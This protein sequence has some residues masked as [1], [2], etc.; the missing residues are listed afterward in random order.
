MSADGK[1]V[2][3]HIPES[4]RRQLRSEVGFGCPWDRCGVPYLEYH[5]FDPPF[6]EEAHHRPEGMIALC[7]MHHARA[8][9]LTVEQ[10]RK[11]K[12]NR[13]HGVEGRFD[14][15]R[16]EIVAIVGG[17]Y[18]HE[19]PNV[20]VFNGVPVIYFSR[21]AEG[22]LLLSV[23]M[24]TKSDEPRAWLDRNDWEILGNPID[25]KCNTNGDRLKVEYA[26]GDQFEIRFKEWKSPS[27]LFKAH[28][29]LLSIH[30]DMKFPLVTA[31]VSMN[32]AD[33]AINLSEK[34]SVDGGVTITGSVI[35]RSPNGFVF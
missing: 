11:L 5:H 10:C 3:R 13:A 24:L 26:N 22:H 14:W 32:V 17:N 23:R 30:A 1:Q 33:A 16:H 20:V 7:P 27:E 6:H 4:V 25:V 28:P 31:S 29:S 12:S 21:D 18:Y 15:M 34:R 9:S 19:V 8:D 2:G 35:S